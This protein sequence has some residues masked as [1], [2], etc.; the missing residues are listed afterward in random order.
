MIAAYLQP[1]DLDTT[2]MFCE[3]TDLS[4]D[5]IFCLMLIY[6]ITTECMPEGAKQI[7]QDC[8]SNK[9]HE[10]HLLT[11]DN[12]NCHHASVRDILH[13]LKTTLTAFL[14]L[15]TPLRCK[16]CGKAE[17][18]VES[19][20]E[21]WPMKESMPQYPAW[22]TGCVLTSWA[23]LQSCLWPSTAEHEAYREEWGHNWP[24]TTARCQGWNPMSYCRPFPKLEWYIHSKDS[25]LPW[26]AMCY[27]TIGPRN[28]SCTSKMKN[29]A[30]DHI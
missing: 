7:L 21:R 11:L 29:I 30:K 17:G 13:A 16:S 27:S 24:W 3:S 2:C 22:A 19:G 18:A 6:S 23:C 1:S 9:R 10:V 14:T 5:N 28:V 26:T 8:T 15:Y 4:I 20:R 25:T 12:V